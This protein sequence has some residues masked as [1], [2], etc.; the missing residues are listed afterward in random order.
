MVGIKNG[1]SV[2]TKRMFPVYIREEHNRKE[3]NETKRLGIVGL[4]P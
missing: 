3:V 2:V 4:A 1:I